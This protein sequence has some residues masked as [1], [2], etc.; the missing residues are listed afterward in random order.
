MKVL[1]V[2]GI[3]GSGKTTTVVNIIRELKQ[4]GY[5]VGSVKEIHCKQFAIDTA[6][7]NT[8]LHRKAG[9]ELVTARGPHETDILYQQKLSIEKILSFYD[10]DYLILEGVNDINAPVIVTAHDTTGIEQ[11]LDYRTLLISGV[12]AKELENYKGQPV[13][14]S[15]VDAKR[16]TDIIEQKV[17]DFMPNFKPECCD[18][19]GFDCHTL[20]QKILQGKKKRTDCKIGQ[21]KI[22]LKI[23]DQEI[24]IV[25]FVE[26]ILNNVIMGIVQELDGYDKDA[27]IKITIGKNGME[28]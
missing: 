24:A 8:D 18:A 4:R 9:A 12:V 3:S 11:K 23:N 13:L 19:C 27:N 5:S 28:L 16:I 22:T 6:G 21:E 1:S 10:Q 20:L 15:M 14:N 25:P 2:I 26:K 17:P 7:T